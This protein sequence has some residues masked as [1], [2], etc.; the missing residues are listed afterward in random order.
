VAG[1]HGDAVRVRVAA[2]PVEGAANRELV[3]VLARALRIR[4]SAITIEAGS[5]GRDKR[6]RV[7]GLDAAAVRALLAPALSVD[8]PRGDN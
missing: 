6:V 3:Q 7:D 5:L 4:A 1:F 2:R 8:T